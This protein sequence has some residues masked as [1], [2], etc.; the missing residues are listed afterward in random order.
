MGAAGSMHFI[1]FVADIY[2]EV[3]SSFTDLG[4]KS[5]CL[6]GGRIRHDSATK[7]IE[8]YGYSVVSLCS[9]CQLQT[10]EW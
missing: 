5:E 9:N 8:V 2:D 1:L 10:M 3:T 6:G 4:L 7:T